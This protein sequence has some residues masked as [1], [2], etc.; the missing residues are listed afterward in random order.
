LLTVNDKSEPSEAVL[1]VQHGG[2]PVADAKR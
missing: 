2:T 1:E